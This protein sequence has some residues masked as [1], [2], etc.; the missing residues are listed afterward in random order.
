MIEAGNVISLPT[1]FPKAEATQATAR[2]AVAAI[3]GG[4]LDKADFFITALVYNGFRI[5]PL[6]LPVGVASGD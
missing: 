3:Y 2:E 1:R 6:N 4:D 5:V